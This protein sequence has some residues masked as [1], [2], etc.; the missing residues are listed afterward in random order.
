MHILHDY[1]H[2]RSSVWHA[3]VG[4]VAV[5]GS[6]ISFRLNAGHLLPVAV[7]L[8]LPTTRLTTGR[9]LLTAP[10]PMHTS[11]RMRPTMRPWGGMVTIC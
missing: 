2:S 10:C 7:L 11:C 5:E 4:T 3:M 6:C 9:S 1:D 8:V